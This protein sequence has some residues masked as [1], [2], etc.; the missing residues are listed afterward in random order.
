MARPQKKGLDYFPWDCHE[1]IKVRLLQG[2]F[3]LVGFAIF[4]KLLERIYGE[5][6]YYM[7]WNEDIALLFTLEN[8]ADRIKVLDV[9]DEC[10]K[11]GLFDQEMFQKY[12]ILTSRGIQKR[13]LMMTEKRTGTKIL[14]EYALLSAQSELVSVEKT[15]V[16]SPKT[17]VSDG[18]KYTKESKGNKKKENEL[19]PIAHQ[20]ARVTENDLKNEFENLWKLYPNKKSKSKAMRSYIKARTR[21]QN[22]VTY[23]EVKK[24]IEAYNEYI[25]KTGIDMQ[26]VKHGST[27]FYQ[28]CW[29]DTYNMDELNTKKSKKSS[30]GW[31]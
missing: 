25:Q 7:E 1:D 19:K 9:V 26:Y 12:S 24:G 13:Y 29:N 10:I 5:E 31:Y 20:D 11:R 23:E 2:A 8:N 18:R 3:G 16:S 22:Q 28:E 27:W 14:D 15:G 17:D 30:N 6:G 21:K 4:V